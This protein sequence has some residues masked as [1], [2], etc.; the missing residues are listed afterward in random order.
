MDANS[1]INKYKNT[2]CVGVSEEPDIAQSEHKA[3]RNQEEDQDDC[4]TAS[5]SRST[6]WAQRARRLRSESHVSEHDEA[7]RSVHEARNFQELSQCPQAEQPYWQY[8]LTCA[9]KRRRGVVPP[10]DWLDN[11]PQDCNQNWEIAAQN[12]IGEDGTRSQ[13]PAKQELRRELN[14]D[15]RTHAQNGFVARRTKK[16]S[17]PCRPGQADNRLDERAVRTAQTEL[18]NRKAHIEKSKQ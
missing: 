9:Y 11:R 15:C 2:L 1:I 18:K 10:N 3:V 13:S 16:L 17:S 12:L 4:S 8:S 14:Q 6:T 7:D 5:S